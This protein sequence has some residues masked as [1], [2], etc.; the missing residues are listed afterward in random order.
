MSVNIGY[1]VEQTMLCLGAFT[2]LTLVGLQVLVAWRQQGNKPR[3]QILQ[4]LLVCDLFLVGLLECLIAIDPRGLWGIFDNAFV[5][6]TL[7]DMAVLSLLFGFMAWTDLVI[8]AVGASV[9]SLDRYAKM[10]PL[11]LT[12]FVPVLMLW[13]LAVIMNMEGDL[14]DDLGYRVKLM[15]VIDG[16]MA[17]STVIMTICKRYLFSILTKDEKNHEDVRRL[18]K[19][20][21]LLVLVTVFCIL[22]SLLNIPQQKLGLTFKQ[23]IL[24]YRSDEYVPLLA[25]V[26]HVSGMAMLFKVCWLPLNA[27]GIAAQNNNGKQSSAKQSSQD[28]IVQSQQPPSSQRKASRSQ[29]IEVQVQVTSVVGTD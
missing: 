6:A 26:V 14:T 18:K 1:L 11:W 4:R 2:C 5:A 16:F 10:F 25:Y 17:A 13:V 22:L 3:V 29:Q 27:P 28:G 8:R 7:R 15:F 19:S 24:V 23:A 21:K 12:S 20:L 9:P